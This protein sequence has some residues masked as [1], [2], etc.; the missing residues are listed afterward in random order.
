MLVATAGLAGLLLLVATAMTAAAHANLIE[1]DPANGA[2]VPEAPAEITLT[3]DEPVQVRDDS[4]QVIDAS[5]AGL[6]VS[7]RT[8][9]SSV[10]VELPDGLDDG[11]YVV[12]W[13]V[14]SADTHAVAGGFLFSIGAPSDASASVDDRV[15][16]PGVRTAL[17]ITRAAGY[18]GLLVAVGM[19]VFRVAVLPPSMRVSR[20]TDRLDRPVP[21]AVAMA[22]AALALQLPLTAAQQS[23]EGLHVVVDP[24][25][26]R[27]QAAAD[28]G[29][30]VVLV[31]TGT[32]VA[33]AAG[34]RAA[35]GPVG[36][37]AVFAGG[38]IA[39]GSLAVVG[40][41]RTF[42]PAWLVTGSHLLHVTTAAVWLGGLVALWLT[43][44]RAMREDPAAGGAVV[45][46]FSALAAPLVLALAGLGVT[47]GW[48][49]LGSWTALFGTTYGVVLLVKVGVALLVVAVAAVNRFRLMPALLR[50]PSQPMLRRT[51]GVEAGVLVAVL[52]LTGFLVDNNPRDGVPVAPEDG[53]A[54]VEAQTVEREFSGGRLSLRV[55][56]GTLGT[57]AVEFDLAGPDGAPLEPLAEP[58]VRLSLPAAGLGPFDRPVTPTAPG[59]YQVTADFPLEG[60]WTIE[61][62]VRIS[63]FDE[64]VVRIPLGV[65]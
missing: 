23:G 44:P 21:G 32:M 14:I 2:V 49:T 35:L 59:A 43:L 38:A 60:E 30:A 17:A 25:A 65:R 11:T 29:L 42:G 12:S 6:D 64:P 26:W 1:T 47:L 50:D 28:P 16:D 58:R 51:V 36:A 7:A 22:V 52:A 3:F 9:D 15:A 19:V 63:E 54:T 39:L 53:G 61:I 46:R 41:T 27:E 45:A 13:R 33:A 55:T 34:R 10:I 57:N 62:S 24:E 18:L 56:P 31:I 20:W 5:G 37:A 4:I 48:R 8:S 40:H